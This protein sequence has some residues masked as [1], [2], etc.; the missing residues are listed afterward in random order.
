[1]DFNVMNK[2]FKYLLG[3]ELLCIFFTAYVITSILLFFGLSI[4]SWILPLSYI[5]V[6]CVFFIY[7]FKTTQKLRF[8]IFFYP[9]I[10]IIISAALGK[11]IWDYSYDGMAYHQVA[12]YSLMNG[13]N[14]F[15]EKCPTDII[16]VDH[17]AKGMETMSAIIASTFNNLEVGKS[18]NFIFVISAFLIIYDVLSRFLPNKK[19]FFLISSSVLIIFSPVVICQF[20]TF[21]IDFMSYILIVLI[22][23]NI[24]LYE[25]ENTWIYIIMIGICLCF[26]ISIKF[27]IAFWCGL[28]LLIYC[29]YLIFKKQ[30]G[31]IRRGL[32]CT[33]ASTI[34]GIFVLSYNPYI[35][36]LKDGHHILH[37]IMGQEKVDIMTKSTPYEIKD[38]NNFSSVIY[39]LFSRPNN[40][41]K[42]V[43][44]SRIDKI[45][46]SLIETG[47]TDSRLGG[48]GFLFPEILFFSIFSLIVLSRRNSREY[49]NLLLILSILF[50]SLFILPSGWWARYVPFFYLFP[51]LI[52]LYIEKWGQIN[53]LIKKILFG[54]LLLNASIITIS[55]TS[56][57]YFANKNIK[58]NF[59]LLKDNKNIRMKSENYGFNY[60]LESAGIGII[61]TDSAFFELKMNGP[62]VFLVEQ[63]IEM[64]N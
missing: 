15:Y 58:Y 27:N 2:T 4:H 41:L 37:P 6:A 47:N 61:P 21:Y 39:S 56:N 55:V 35:T 59:E 19:R 33:L 45:K 62:K 14:P 60:K 54:M 3:T 13:W 9:L 53:I 63:D 38:L 17:Y 20:L 23:A 7:A 42:K 31:R 5:F 57:A 18:I 28:E 49:K 1:M 25:K 46:S 30:W 12:I 64:I 36:N 22:T 26:A 10:F 16:W 11:H 50:I 51:I 40:Y 34:I 32:I 8:G 52:F 29:I 48:F 44:L 24:Y 43:E